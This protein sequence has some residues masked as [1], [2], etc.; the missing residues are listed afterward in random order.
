MT[1]SKKSWRLIAA[2]ATI[3]IA[4]SVALAMPAQAAEKSLGNIKCGTFLPA[5]PEIHSIS[6]AKGNVVH[7]IYGAW[8]CR[9]GR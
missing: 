6:S 7:E 3:A 4:S 2:G 1:R 9:H 5:N 8:Q